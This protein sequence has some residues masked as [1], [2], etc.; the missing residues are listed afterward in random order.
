VKILRDHEVQLELL[1]E[2]SKQKTVGG[3]PG[4]RAL[5]A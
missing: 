1:A 2:I 3:A 4:A 5:V